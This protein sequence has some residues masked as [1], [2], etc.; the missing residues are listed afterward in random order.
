MYAAN[1]N[2]KKRAGV[3]IDWYLDSYKNNLRFHII[4]NVFI[5]YIRCLAE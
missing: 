2:N 1:T 3:T 4:L 5:C